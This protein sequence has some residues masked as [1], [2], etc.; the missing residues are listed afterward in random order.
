MNKSMKMEKLDAGDKPLVTALNK[1]DLLNPDDSEGW[2]TDY[3]SP[4]PVS[5]RTG[6]GIPELVAVV[7][8]KLQGLMTPVRL[9]LPYSKGDLVSLIYER[10]H[11]EREEY[12]ENG[13]LIAGKL[14]THLV[15]RVQD[16][17]LLAA[18]E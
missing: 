9:L 8:E 5:A 3:P 12:A 7:D 11:V 16:Y 6:E 4:A 14:P 2:K 15:G 18:A 13:T 17:E 1:I 10:G